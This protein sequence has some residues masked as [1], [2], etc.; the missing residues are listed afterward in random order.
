MTDPTFS[1]RVRFACCSR[2]PPSP[3]RSPLLCNAPKVALHTAAGQAHAPASVAA[4]GRS[5]AKSQPP[6]LICA[7]GLLFTTYAMRNSRGS[8]RASLFC[9]P[10]A[11]DLQ[12]HILLIVGCAI[13]ARGRCAVTPIAN[14]LASSRISRDFNSRNCRAAPTAHPSPASLPSTFLLYLPGRLSG[15]ILKPRPYAWLFLFAW[16]RGLSLYFA[17]RPGLHL[18]PVPHLR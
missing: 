18:P 5:A 1:A 2:S 6:P 8:V 17:A 13:H 16:S 7:A 11:A 4:A 3:A 15:S 14:S 10:G 9:A 12:S